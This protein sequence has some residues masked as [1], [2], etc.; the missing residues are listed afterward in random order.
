V[1]IGFVLTQSAVG[2][3]ED[4]QADVL[5]GC[6]IEGACIACL[7]CDVMIVPA[8]GNRVLFDD[9]RLKISLAALPE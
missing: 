8:S 4:V 7:A 3:G 2:G 1:R 6:G 5:S 9:V